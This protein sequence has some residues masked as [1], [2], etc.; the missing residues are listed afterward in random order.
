MLVA[1]VV[2]ARVARPIAATVNWSVCLLDGWWFLARVFIGT[3][4]EVVTAP[5]TLFRFESGESF[6]I[7][8]LTKNVV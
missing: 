8:L 4:C 5:D 3:G 1:W 6:V 2:N 7:F